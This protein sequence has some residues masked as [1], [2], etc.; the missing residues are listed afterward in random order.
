MKIAWCVTASDP[1]LSTFLILLRADS[2]RS[3]VGPV[4]HVAP[5]TGHKALGDYLNIGGLAED[6]YTL[7]RGMFR[8]NDKEKAG[9]VYADAHKRIEG[10]WTKFDAGSIDAIAINR[11]VRLVDRV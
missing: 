4:N 5:P 10:K 7:Y 8:F 6:A 1:P 11:L 3:S 2:H 9:Y